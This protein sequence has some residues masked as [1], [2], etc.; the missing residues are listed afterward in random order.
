MVDNK[1]ANDINTY[2]VVMLGESMVGKTCII[3]RYIKKTYSEYN[4]ASVAGSFFSD[5]VTIKPEGVSA[6]VKVKLQIW[7]TAGSEQ[8]RSLAGI[9]YKGVNAV[10]LVYDSTNLKTFE[11]LNYWV[12]ELE[13]KCDEKVVLGVVASKIDLS[14]NEEVSI[15]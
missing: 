8:F 6:P 12:N 3:N 14:H 15:K 11:G 4:E 9:Y 10:C 7:D 2:K 5:I 13:E 1:A